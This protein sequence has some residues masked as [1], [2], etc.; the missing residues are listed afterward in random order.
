MLRIPLHVDQDGYDQIIEAKE[1]KQ[2]QKNLFENDVYEQ[3]EDCGKKSCWVMTEKE[4]AQEISAIKVCLAACGFKES[5]PE[6]T[7]SPV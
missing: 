6:R 7:D 4:M 1:N 5:L 3:V 2:K